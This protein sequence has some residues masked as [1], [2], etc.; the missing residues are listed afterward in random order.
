MESL[1]AVLGI[2]GLDP[3]PNSFVALKTKPHSAARLA[4][5]GAYGVRKAGKSQ[6]ANGGRD[7]DRTSDPCDVNAVLIPLSYAPT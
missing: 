7:W 4:Q 1:F 3:E 2:E 6:E 5:T